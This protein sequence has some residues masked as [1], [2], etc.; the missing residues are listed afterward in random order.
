MFGGDSSGGG[1][2]PL[3]AL[4]SRWTGAWKTM[5]DLM[6]PAFGYKPKDS[7]GS[8]PSLLGQINQGTNP[9]GSSARKSLLGE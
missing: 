8:N 3:G 4:F 2:G 1:G 9:Y 5:G 6:G 7:S